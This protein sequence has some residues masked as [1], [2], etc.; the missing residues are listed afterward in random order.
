[1]NGEIDEGRFNRRFWIA[2]RVYRCPPLLSCAGLRQHRSYL[3]LGH[4]FLPISEDREAELLS[5]A[6]MSSNIALQKVLRGSLKRVACRVGTASNQPFICSTIIENS[7]FPT[8]SRRNEAFLAIHSFETRMRGVSFRSSPDALVVAFLRT[9]GWW[10][11][12]VLLQRPRLV[13]RSDAVYLISTWKS[14]T[15]SLILKR[16]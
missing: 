5:D 13:R 6:V 1:M 8:D 2:H 14:H 16:L 10:K 15:C 7:N 3:A 11:K 9:S 12:V 4:V